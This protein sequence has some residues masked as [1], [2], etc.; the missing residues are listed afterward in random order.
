[1]IS[2]NPIP[3]CSAAHNLSKDLRMSDID[4]RLR[5]M[6]NEIPVI[7]E[8]T[9]QIQESIREI[10]QDN[11]GM[12][13]DLIVAQKETLKEIGGISGQM[14]EA[15]A[16]FKGDMQTILQTGIKA[17]AD[18]HGEWISKIEKRSDSMSGRIDRIEIEKASSNGFG[19]GMT[20]AAKIF[21]AVFGSVF[22]AILT[23]TVVQW[24]KSL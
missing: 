24:A 8:R 14:K 16:V 17:C 13:N 10:K 7:H 3:A 9:K 5:N 22:G 18:G 12:R 21:W 6:E 4:Q 15:I 20:T 2:L 23:F 19:R 1:M 11:A